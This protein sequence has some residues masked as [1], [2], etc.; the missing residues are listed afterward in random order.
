MTTRRSIAGTV[1]AAA[2]VSVSANVL[3]YHWLLLFIAV[4]V[5]QI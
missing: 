3:Y 1:S 4:A 2:A 5:D